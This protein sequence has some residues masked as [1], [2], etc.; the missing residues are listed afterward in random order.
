MSEAQTSGAAQPEART[1]A[2]TSEMPSGQPGLPDAN[3]AREALLALRGV[4]ILAR[5][6]SLV[7]HLVEEQARSIGFVISG[8]I[9]VEV[10]FS[11]RTLS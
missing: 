3:A 5:T 2:R 1:E 7:A 6:A 10:V 9:L 8:A 4:P 11:W